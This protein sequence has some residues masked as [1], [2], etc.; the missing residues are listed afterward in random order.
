MKSIC[1][2]FVAI[3]AVTGTIGCSMCCGPYDLDYPAYG[4]K[5]ERV[6]PAYGRVGSIFSDPNA[7]YAGESADSN[8]D[9]PPPVRSS[10]PDKKPSG[11][12]DKEKFRKELES[13]TPRDNPANGA[14][15]ELPQPDDT[16]PTASRLWKERPLRSQQHWR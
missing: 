11:S 14:P 1:L 2:I 5:H 16:G 7:G 10:N 12:D 9:E 13:I 8:L 3:V 4:G 15:D 6:D